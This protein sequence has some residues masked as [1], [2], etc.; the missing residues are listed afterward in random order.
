MVGYTSGCIAGCTMVGIHPPGIYT[1]PYHGGYTPLPGIYT[2]CTPGYTTVTRP[3]AACPLY[4]GEVT[5]M[6]REGALGSEKRK[7][8]GGSPSSLSGLLNVLRL[9]GLSAQSCSLS[10]GKDWIK[11]G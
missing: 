1:L 3:S 9:M 2:L 10:P 11:I 6:R 4:H 8:L 7:G 5:T